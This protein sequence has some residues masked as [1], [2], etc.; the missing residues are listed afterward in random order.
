MANISDSVCLTSFLRHL[1]SVLRGSGLQDVSYRLIILTEQKEWL[2]R[3]FSE[4][5]GVAYGDKY[6]TLV[7]H[8]ILVSLLE[9]LCTSLEV[10]LDVKYSYLAFKDLLST[11]NHYNHHCVVKGKTLPLCMSLSEQWRSC[12]TIEFPNL[13]DAYLRSRV[14]WLSSALFNRPSCKQFLQ[15]VEFEHSFSRALIG[16]IATHT[17]L[18]NAE[19][20]MRVEYVSV[21]LFSSCEASW[22]DCLLPEAQSES[23]RLT[24]IHILSRLWSKVAENLI[25]RAQ[26][27]HRGSWSM[28]HFVPWLLET[29]QLTGKQA[30]R[31]HQ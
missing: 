3:I 20:E 29:S 28:E 8:K 31:N 4:D 13:I 24:S 1:L 7:L 25:A 2:N 23:L 19:N 17:P 30:G 11:V 15:L 12:Q 5:G 26:P 27:V 21:E 22:L 14:K 16:I 9:I 18:I 10:I 6:S